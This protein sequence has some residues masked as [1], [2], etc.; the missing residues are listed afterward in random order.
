VQALASLGSH[1][2]IVQY[3]GAWIECDWLYVQMEMCESC[4]SSQQS[5]Q[6]SFGEA[7]IKQLLR[8]IGSALDHMHTRGLV[9]LDIK[10]ENVFF[11]QGAA[12]DEF[13]IPSQGD[14]IIGKCVAECEK[15]FLVPAAHR[16]HW[17]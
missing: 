14:P 17:G 7:Q 12:V 8:E 16:A 10:P 15:W 4:L 6:R 9:H 5:T 2:N 13:L 11:T 1:K 3:F